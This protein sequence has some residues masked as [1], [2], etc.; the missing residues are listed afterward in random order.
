MSHS[1]GADDDGSDYWPIYITRSDGQGYTNLDNFPLNEDDS[2]DVAARE[3]WEV[4][5]A[6]H[7]QRELGPRDDSTLISLFLRP[8]FESDRV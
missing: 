3:R 6:G 5:V 7:L 1:G 2:S 4:I 8:F